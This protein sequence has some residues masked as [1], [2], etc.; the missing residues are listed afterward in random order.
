MTVGDKVTGHPSGDERFKNIDRTI[1][2]FKE[3]TRR[4]A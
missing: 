1:K 3:R 4:A 2:A